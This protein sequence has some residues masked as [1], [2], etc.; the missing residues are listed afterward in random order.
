MAGAG[1]PFLFYNNVKQKQFL[2]NFN[3]V[4]KKYL[5]RSSAEKNANKAFQQTLEQQ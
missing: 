5:M 3:Y 1:N 4:S 2:I